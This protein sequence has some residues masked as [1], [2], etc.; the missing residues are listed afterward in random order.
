MI[1]PIESKFKKKVPIT[2]T[3]VD[4]NGNLENSTM[5]LEKPEPKLEEIENKSLLM[6]GR[7]NE[8]I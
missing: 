5:K 3:E 2:T 4:T 6:P 7:F 1:Y 8:Y